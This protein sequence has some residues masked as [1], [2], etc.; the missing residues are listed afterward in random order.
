[1]LVL[2]FKSPGDFQALE[3]MLGPLFPQLNVASDQI[4]TLHFARFLPLDDQHLAVVSEYDSAFDQ[5]IEDF[6]K[7]LGLVF[8]ALF[9]HVTDP[10]PTPVLKNAPA[11]VRWVAAHNV[12]AW[13][14]YSAYPNLEVQ[15]IR[16]IAGPVPMM[17]TWSG[18]PTQSPLDVILPIKSPASYTALK[19]LIPKLHQ[20]LFDGAAKSGVI[21]FARF[22][23]LDQGRLGFHTI[24][25][26]DLNTYVGIL[27]RELGSLFDGL[28]DHVANPPPGPVQQNPAALETW[29]RAHTI[30][31]V[32]FYSACPSLSVQKVQAL[33]AKAA[34]ASV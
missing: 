18:P 15:D 5:Y 6:A 13:D 20:S 24:Y 19:D 17:S 23:L 10:P 28:F 26:G 12:D 21:H 1:M 11:L 33:A 3:T 27:A 22:V 2:P 9:L 30:T 29:L 34:F 4:A 25:D 14:F 16:T 7:F 8:D 31:P 32:W